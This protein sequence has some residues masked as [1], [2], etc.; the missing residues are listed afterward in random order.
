MANWLNFFAVFL[1]AGAGGALRYALAMKFPPS[2]R[3]PLG[4][5][6]ANLAGCLVIGLLAALR[7]SG[8]LHDKP[9]AW[10][11]FATGFCGGLTT[12]STLAFEIVEFFQAKEPGP[13]LGY[14]AVSVIGGVVLAAAAYAGMRALLK[15]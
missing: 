2:P 4:T 13:G 8:P 15:S 14:L 1:G 7:E 9:L 11:L 6:I 12:L 3:W 5:L 10:L